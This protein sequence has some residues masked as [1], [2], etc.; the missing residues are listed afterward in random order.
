MKKLS[1]LLLVISAL[2]F[3]Y[4]TSV[5]GLDNQGVLSLFLCAV[6]M[7]YGVIGLISSLSKQF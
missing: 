5:R 2:L 4:S 1:I 6:C 3:Y 7:L